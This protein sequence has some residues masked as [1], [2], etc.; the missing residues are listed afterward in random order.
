[1]YIL[2]ACFVI[3]GQFIVA[4]G[5]S[6]SSIYLMLLGRIVFGLGGESLNIA[7]NAMIIKWFNKGEISWAFAL[8]ISFSRI[9]SSL[10]GILSPRIAAVCELLN[11]D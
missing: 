9:G 10:N 4:M 7:Q 1:M 6:R 3:I 2:L 5:G 8:K 11:K